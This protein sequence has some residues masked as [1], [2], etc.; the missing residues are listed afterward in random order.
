MAGSHL[1]LQ[2]ELQKSQRSLLLLLRDVT[3]ILQSDFV[4]RA[5]LLCFP[6]AEPIIQN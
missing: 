2:L 6:K 4:T 3:V 1:C 5:D